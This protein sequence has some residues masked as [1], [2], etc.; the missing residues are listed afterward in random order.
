MYVSGNWPL[1]THAD[2]TSTRRATFHKRRIS[3]VTFTLAHLYAVYMRV[4]VARALSDFGLLGSKVHKNL[5][6]SEL[7]AHE[8][9]CNIW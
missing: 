3:S 9:P 2:P 6:F 7:D 8:P 1:S 4:G 5:W